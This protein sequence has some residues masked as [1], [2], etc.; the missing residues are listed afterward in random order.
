MKMIEFWFTFI[1]KGRLMFGFFQG[2]NKYLIFGCDSLSYYS[3][4]GYKI[5][6]NIHEYILNET[7]QI[8][9]LIGEDSIILYING[10]YQSKFEYG[11]ESD[12]KG[13]PITFAIF[14]EESSFHYLSFYNQI[15][16][17]RHIQYIYNLNYKILYP[18][19]F[20]NIY[21]M[22]S[23]NLSITI[24]PKFIWDDEERENYYRKYQYK[25][26]YVNFKPINRFRFLGSH[27]MDYFIKMKRL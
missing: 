24:T 18:S 5:F 15:L 1:Q 8:L 26:S 6:K 13:E 14:E 12:I 4:D 16:D 23:D 17:N 21:K 9:I 10:E 27:R 3:K 19:L 20:Q 2:E 11:L 25:D 7:Y 22:S